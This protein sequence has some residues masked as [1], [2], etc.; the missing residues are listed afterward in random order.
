MENLLILREGLGSWPSR[1]GAFGV[2]RVDKILEHV[3]RRGL[4]KPDGE[5]KDDA[6][7]DRIKLGPERHEELRVGAATLRATVLSCANIAQI[8]R[9]PRDLVQDQARRKQ[10][11]VCR[12][13]LECIRAMLSLGGV[14]CWSTR[15]MLCHRKRRETRCDGLEQVRAREYK[16]EKASW[17]HNLIVMNSQK[18]LGAGGYQG[19]AVYRGS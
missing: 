8:C 15:Q 16:H 19:W 3:A 1:V 17:L 18:K 11:R 2:I 4:V 10:L 6:A 5:G 9:I 13:T 7:E 14:A 12:D